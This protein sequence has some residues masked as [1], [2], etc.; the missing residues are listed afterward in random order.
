MGIEP[1]VEERLARIGEVT[2]N[3]LRYFATAYLK[4]NPGEEHTIPERDLLTAHMPQLA[5]VIAL[6]EGDDLDDRAMLS[7]PH[8]VGIT[9]PP[10]L[11]STPRGTRTLPPSERPAAPYRPEPGSDS[12]PV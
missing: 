10:Y 12:P 4:T 11:T 7:T 8:S 3:G 1:G 2:D 5:N 6:L 9:P